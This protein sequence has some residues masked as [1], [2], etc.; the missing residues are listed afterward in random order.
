MLAFE[1]LHHDHCLPFAV[2]NIANLDVRA[3]GKRPSRIPH[4]HHI[5][6]EVITLWSP[7]AF[8]ADD[9]MNVYQSRPIP[10]DMMSF[11]LPGPLLPFLILRHDDQSSTETDF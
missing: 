10:A 11:D 8:D 5:P 6:L 3:T 7:M 4:F 9:T 2:A 1:Y